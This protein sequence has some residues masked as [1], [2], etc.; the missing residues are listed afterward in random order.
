[1]MVDL[2]DVAQDV[3]LSETGV[4]DELGGGEW[5]RLGCPT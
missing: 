3:V 2:T 5:C 1:M 4:G